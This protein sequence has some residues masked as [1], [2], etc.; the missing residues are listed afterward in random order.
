[1]E[2]NK[3]NSDVKSDSMP[4]LI[5]DS[6]ANKNNV[7]MGIVIPDKNDDNNTPDVSEYLAHSEETIVKL[8]NLLKQKRLTTNNIVDVAVNMMKFVENFQD[9]SGNQKK[10]LVLFSIEKYTNLD[11][12]VISS[13][14]VISHLMDTLISVEKGRIAIKKLSKK[15]GSCFKF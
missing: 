11:Q 10:E 9:L 2:D 15:C 6:P 5:L 7:V 13:I 1:M 4:Q 8:G 12:N 3:E 14:N